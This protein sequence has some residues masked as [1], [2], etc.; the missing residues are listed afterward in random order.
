VVLS[1]VQTLYGLYIF[2]KID[3]NRSYTPPEEFTQFI[4]RARS[5]EKRLIEKNELSQHKKI[6]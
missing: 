3:Y 6:I 1:R 2:Q 4:K 5:T